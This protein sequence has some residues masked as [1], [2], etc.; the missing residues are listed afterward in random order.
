MAI[1]EELLHEL[2]RDGIP[3]SS[4]PIATASRQLAEGVLEWIS[5][6]CNKDS[7][8]TFT[9]EVVKALNGAFPE[10]NF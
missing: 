4:G 6:D 5:F 8:G 10:P 7:A 2:L 3:R 9:S 1:L